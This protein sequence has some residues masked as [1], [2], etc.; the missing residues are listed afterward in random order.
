[1]RIPPARPEIENLHSF[2]SLSPSLSS[3]HPPN[4][5]TAGPPPDL[6]PRLRLRLR[7]RKPPQP[8]VYPKPYCVFL[9]AATPVRLPNGELAVPVRENLVFVPCCDSTITS[10]DYTSRRLA[11]PIL[12]YPTLFEQILSQNGRESQLFFGRISTL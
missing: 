12:L 8:I 3:L 10:Q 11:H 7:L 1:M 9:A 6:R 5:P 4:I 2:V